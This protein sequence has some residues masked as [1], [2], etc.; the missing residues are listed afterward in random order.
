MEEKEE[1][2]K[3]RDV[4]LRTAL[5]AIDMYLGTCDGDGAEFRK[6]FIKVIHEAIE[7]SGTRMTRIA[8]GNPSVSIEEK[9]QHSYRMA[10]SQAYLAALIELIISGS[11]QWDDKVLLPAQF[12]SMLRTVMAR[13]KSLDLRSGEIT[14]L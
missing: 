10:V 8:L 4:V 14:E 2:R 13:S 3:A 11:A 9:A 7:S 1:A 12:K 6:R 5:D